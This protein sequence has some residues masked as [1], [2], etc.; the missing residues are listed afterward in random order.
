MTL[1]TTSETVILT[2]TRGFSHKIIPTKA[3]MLRFGS[4]QSYQDCRAAIILP[5][6]LLRAFFL[7]VKNNQ[8]YEFAVI[9][10]YNKTQVFL[11]Q[12]QNSHPLCKYMVGLLFRFFK[13]NISSLF[14][15]D[16]CASH[17][18]IANVA[19]KIMTH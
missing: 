7:N 2:L 4:K 12:C 16:A 3:L 8:K 1:N 10:S 5:Q 15:P 19:C 11:S 13:S 6:V 18:Y 9:S 14:L 17:F